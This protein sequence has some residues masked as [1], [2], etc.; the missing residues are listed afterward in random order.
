MIESL[1]MAGFQPH[2]DK[3]VIFD[4][5]ATS[6]VGPNDAGK[7]AILRALGFVFLNDPSAAKEVVNWDLTKAIVT[8]KVDGKKVKRVRGKRDNYYALN[9]RKF[10]DL[11]SGPPKLI[12]DILRV[13]DVNFQGQFDRHFWF[14][15]TPGKVSK[16]LNEI[17]HLNDIDAALDLAAVKVRKLQSALTDAKD[18]FKKAENESARLEWVA[19][20]AKA[21]DRMKKAKEKL[22]KARRKT[23]P[24]ASAVASG[25]RLRA[26][27]DTAARGEIGAANLLYHCRAALRA[28]QSV[29][30]LTGLVKDLE[31][32][33]RLT[34]LPDVKPVEVAKKK[35]DKVADR[36]RELSHLIRDISQL[37]SKKC[38]ADLKV[39]NLERKVAK[40]TANRCPVCGTKTKAK[41]LL[42]SSATYTSVPPRR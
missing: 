38:V 42:S 20:Y 26:D 10:K 1:K 34:D 39:K 31:K 2:K 35:A 7:S 17:V 9:G 33:Q 30:S 27:K 11:R 16:H 14:S 19:E 13:G 40:K 24:V 5:L 15:D 6:F 37:R 12:Q 36:F 8:L 32:L 3:V 4:L 22:D 28:E 18:R 41:S 25:E 23:L 29:E 21:F